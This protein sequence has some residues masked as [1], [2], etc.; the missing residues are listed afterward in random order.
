MKP[1]LFVIDI[2]KQFYKIS[3]EAAKSLK[4]AVEYT[5]EAI[6]IFR[7]KQLPVISIQHMDQ[8]NGLVPGNIDFDLPDDLEIEPTDLHIHKTYS[9]SF[10]KT[11]LLEELK[12]MGVDTIILCGFCAE[13]CVLATY[14]GA[15][16]ADLSP[17][18]LKS[19][20]ASYTSKNIAFVEGICE[21]ISLGALE[22][23]LE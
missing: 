12:K 3:D 4:D 6:K 9:N 10:T 23:F 7:R 2:Q 19:G 15:N 17:I 22:K 8:T 16:D 1:A 14:H 11:P 5:N 18:L 13:F 21:I 20:L